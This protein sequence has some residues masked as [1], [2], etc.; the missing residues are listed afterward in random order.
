MKQY[1]YL[2]SKMLSED[3]IREAFRQ[4]RRGKTTRPEIIQI[5]TDSDNEVHRMQEM[6]RNTRPPGVPVENP[7]LAYV[8]APRHPRR[9]FER[10]KWR[11]ICKPEIHEQW[12]HH[13]IILVLEPIISATAYRYSCGSVPD[14]GIHF[15]KKKIEAWIRKDGGRNCR[16]VAKMDI[17][18]FYDNVRHDILFRELQTRIR[19]PWFLH[20]IRLCLSGFRKGLPLGFYLSQWLANYMLEPLDLLIIDSGFRYYM[21]FMD[22]IVIFAANKKALHRMVAE[23]RM[24]L[25]RRFR[26]SLK[27]DWQVFRF[28]CRKRNGDV[29]GRPLDYM[30]FIFYRD[31]TV[32][33]RRILFRATRTARR[34]HRTAA[35][36]RKL[37]RRQV[38]AM[39]SYLG[40][41]KHCCTYGVYLTMI[42]PMINP[43]KLRRIVAA[44]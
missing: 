14:R 8:P 31:R 11:T 19:D 29:T 10:G 15:G 32:L 24:F 39:I 23:I 1:K 6:I 30:G 41:M 12:L 25:G 42:R 40:W 36:G 28:W 5:E 37:Y 21:R 9:I 44:C 13:I 7:A 16:Y 22:D 4:L 3:L 17:R 18:H 35:R 43:R 26:M 34:L 33:R 20:I 2:Y 27:S 38:M